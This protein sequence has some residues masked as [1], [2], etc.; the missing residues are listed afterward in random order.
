MRLRRTLIATIALFL[1]VTQGGC[2][3]GYVLRAACEEAKILWRRQPIES[4]LG[5]EIDADTRA[6]LELTLAARR[7]ARETLGLSVGGSYATLSTVDDEQVVHTVSAVPWNRLEPHTWWF[8][9]VGRVP[10]RGYFDEKDA[11]ALAASLERDGYD[12]SVRSAVAF[13]TLG[14]FDDPL[15]S[16]LLRLDEVQLVRVI[17]HELLHNTLYVPGHGSFNESLASFVG[18]RGAASFF[19]ARGD[20]EKARDAELQWA[21][22]LTFSAF[23]ETSLPELRAAYEKGID[24]AQRAALL[25][26]LQDRFR[27]QSFRTT[28]YRSFGERDLNNAILLHHLLYADRLAVFE[29]N[30]EEHDRDLA[31][32]I[33]S[34]REK[35]RDAQDPFAALG[36]VPQ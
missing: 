2:S 17:L 11:M 32:S 21:D 6:K 33:A 22:A 18:A 1:T 26:S 5:Q 16:N 28:M 10:Y 31:I 23:L 27:E 13:S 8:P 36:P 30:F 24:R 4:V 20:T 7:Y 9:I 12:T 15:L 3:A 35:T 29:R 14:W 34:I 25:R 19:A